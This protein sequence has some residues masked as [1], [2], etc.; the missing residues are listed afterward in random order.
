VERICRAN[1]ILFVV[2]EVITGFGHTGHMFACERYGLEPD[3][4]TFAKGVTSG[5]APLGGVLVSPRVWQPF[6]HDS[7]ENPVFR[8][9]STY[10][11]HAT[12]C[13]V[14][15]RNLDLLD[16][17]GLLPRVAELERLLA[18]ELGLLGIRDGVTGTR[19]AGLLGG[20]TLADELSAET[21]ADEFVEHGFITRPLRGNTLQISPPFITTDTELRQFVEAIG[22]VIAGQNG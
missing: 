4:V 14:A 1:D 19:V 17:E 8:Y 13:A 18:D 16:E 22:T 2:D 20:V 12:A 15:L 7:A 5:Y 6:Y 11:G 21:V 10:S 9:G 3:L